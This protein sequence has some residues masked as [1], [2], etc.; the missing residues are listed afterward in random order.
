ML[1]LLLHSKQKKVAFLQEKVLHQFTELV[2][3]L[4]FHIRCHMS[5]NVNCS[6]Y[7]CIFLNDAESLL[8]PHPLQSIEMYV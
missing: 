1:I 5:I 7:V 6:V 3:G 8:L 2:G 4:F